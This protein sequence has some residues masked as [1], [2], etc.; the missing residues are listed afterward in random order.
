MERSRPKILKIKNIREEQFPADPKERFNALFPAIGNSA[1]KCLFLALSSSDFKTPRQYYND[2]LDVSKRVWRIN[3]SA[4][5]AAFRQ[6]LI[7]I[8]LVAEEASLFDGATEYVVGFRSLEA[9]LHYGQPIARFLLAEAGGLNVSLR[10][11]FGTSNS[12]GETR[13]PVNR[14]IILEVL[15]NMAIGTSTK[16][17]SIADKLGISLS[18]VGVN[19]RHLDKLGYAKYRSADASDEGTRVY[20]LADNSESIEVEK[21]GYRRTLTQEVKELMQTVGR[22]SSR[23]LAR[24]LEDRVPDRDRVYLANHVSTVLAGLAEQGFCEPEIFEDPEAY[25]IAKPTRRG[26]RLV[27]RLI[28][29]I[30]KALNDDLD[31]LERMDNVDWRKYAAPAIARHLAE[32][33][34]AGTN[35]RSIRDQAMEALK[36]IKRHPGV[37]PNEL[38]SELDFFNYQ[39]AEWLLKRGLV[40]KVREGKAVRYYSE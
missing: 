12:S 2:F 1:P 10:T 4:P 6:S 9:G 33:K 25:S 26:K 27:R 35:R 15:N 39:Q 19:L 30:R 29:P 8:G 5:T 32:S 31:T 18:V 13:G 7:G 28:L 37:R 11:L 3:N 24:R 20:V 34:S 38:V 16:T 40:R 14:A 23:D 36:F 17:A 22:A 21:I